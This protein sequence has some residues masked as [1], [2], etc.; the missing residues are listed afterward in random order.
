MMGDASQVRIGALIR[1][2]RQR[3]HLTRVELA[4]AAGLN[5]ST[6]SRIERGHDTTLS[7]VD[8][9]LAAMEL[10]LRVESEPLWDAIDRDIDAAM[11]RSRS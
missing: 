1:A 7:T 10:E 4:T 8:R 2:A 11:G 6:I 3:R 5:T 9:I